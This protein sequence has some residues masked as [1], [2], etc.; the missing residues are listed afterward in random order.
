MLVLLF[1]ASM[2]KLHEIEKKTLEAAHY[3]TKCQMSSCKN[4]NHCMKQVYYHDGRSWKT[5]HR[6]E[7]SSATQWEALMKRSK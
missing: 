5:K 6:V 7:H 2:D 3:G 4:L 1:V